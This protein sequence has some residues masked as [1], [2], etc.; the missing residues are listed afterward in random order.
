DQ[1]HTEGMTAAASSLEFCIQMSIQSRSPRKA[2]DRID[3]DLFETMTN[4]LPADQQ[5][6]IGEQCKQ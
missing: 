4:G 2:G 6:I 1:N 5:I 3:H